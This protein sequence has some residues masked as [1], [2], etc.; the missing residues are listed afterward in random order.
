MW[1]PK[2]TSEEDTFAD[3]AMIIPGLYVASQTGVKS[4]SM[5]KKIEATHI[6]NCA[7]EIRCFYPKEFE[8]LHL[9][10]E[11]DADETLDFEKVVEFMR[12]SLLASNGVCVCHCQAGI[13]RS[14]SYCVA[15]LMIER[16]MSLRDA[17]FLVNSVRPQAG[18]NVGYWEQLVQLEI[19]TFGGPCTLNLEMYYVESFSEMGFEREAIEKLFARYAGDFQLTLS[20]LLRGEKI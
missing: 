2:R 14:V 15:Y 20:A 9:D 3:P 18:P 13:S 17:F 11:D 19:K 4:L 16:Q 5:L 10:L 6:V 8:Y 12:N 7:K 1:H